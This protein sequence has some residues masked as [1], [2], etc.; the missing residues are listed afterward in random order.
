MFSTDD[1]PVLKT[2][3]TNANNPNHRQTT[4][5]RREIHLSFWQLLPMLMEVIHP[6]LFLE[7]LDRA[8]FDFLGQLF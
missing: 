4:R 8:Y 3:E 1:Y 6:L 7:E 2:G 5:F